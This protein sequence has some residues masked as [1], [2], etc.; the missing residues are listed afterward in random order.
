MF[1][2]LYNYTDHLQYRC[3]DKNANHLFVRHFESI[4]YQALRSEFSLPPTRVLPRARHATSMPIKAPGYE[5]VP[6]SS[7]IGSC[8]CVSAK[9]NFIFA[10]G[11]LITLTDKRAL[12]ADKAK[13]YSKMYANI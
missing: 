1:T 5:A 11:N 2:C 4:F 9:L 13:I 7:L 12:R 8:L 3:Q 6:I 10:V